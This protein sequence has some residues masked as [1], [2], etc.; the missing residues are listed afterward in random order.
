M[1]ALDQ[2]FKNVRFSR[3]GWCVND[4]VL[5]GDQMINSLGLPGVGQDQL[6]QN[7]PAHREK[8]NRLNRLAMEEPER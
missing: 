7:V 2:F 6:L 1:F 5:A 3:T 8:L 4:H